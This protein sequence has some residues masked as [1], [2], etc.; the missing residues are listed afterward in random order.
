[1]AID[2]RGASAPNEFEDFYRREFA[3]LAVIA[4]TIVG[5]RSAGE[6]IADEALRR[7]Q[8]EWATT[9]ATAKAQL[10]SRRIA[11]NLASDRERRSTSPITSIVQLGPTA[12]DAAQTRRGDAAIWVAIDQLS[13]RHRAVVALHYLEDWPVEE[14]AGILEIS[15]S[16]TASILTEARS[17]LAQV[18]GDT[19]G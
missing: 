13:P 19:S 12:R 15:E 10:R 6:T 7:V 17:N 16:S 9:P 2:G 11:I 4:G 5:D 8:A 3:P 18:L 1:M 14:I